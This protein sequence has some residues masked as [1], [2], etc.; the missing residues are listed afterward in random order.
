MINIKPRLR[1]Q[2]GL[3]LCCPAFNK[4]LRFLASGAG[5]QPGGLTAR[6]IAAAAGGR[7]AARGL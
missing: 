7:F 2:A 1:N 5:G 6:R 3:L 4:R